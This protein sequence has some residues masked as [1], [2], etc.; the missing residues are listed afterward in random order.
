MR[1]AV[2]ARDT[3]GQSC[4]P[5]RLS[6]GLVLCEPLIQC[7]WKT[8]D[9]VTPFIDFGLRIGDITDDTM[10]YYGLPAHRLLNRRRLS[11]LRNPP[12]LDRYAR[13]SAKHG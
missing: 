13:I 7:G 11:S 8:V 3:A 1:L 12:G 9:D 10:A 6:T 4:L 5:V 2:A